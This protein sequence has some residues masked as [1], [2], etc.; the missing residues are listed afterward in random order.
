M[1]KQEFQICV[2]KQVQL[3]LEFPEKDNATKA[4]ILAHYLKLL[5]PSDG[6]LIII[7]RRIEKIEVRISLHEFVTLR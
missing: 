2:P 5:F 6:E 7:S 3:L 1:R 4:N